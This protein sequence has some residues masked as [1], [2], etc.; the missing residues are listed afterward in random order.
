MISIFKMNVPDL[1]EK[2][3]ITVKVG[4]SKESCAFVRIRFIPREH[5]IREVIGQSIGIRN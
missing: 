1:M 4:V 2:V 3:N 5:M